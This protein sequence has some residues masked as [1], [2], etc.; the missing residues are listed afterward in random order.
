MK[1]I[2]EYELIN[3]GF[4][5]EDYWN[6]CYKGRF[7]TVYTGNGVSSYEAF[8][9]LLEQLAELNI[10]IF[11]FEKKYLKTMSKQQSE[12]RYYYISIRFNL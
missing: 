6:G 8:Q 12:P 11:E 4:Q 2:A 7:G 9:D 5:F 1:T 10:D 3:H